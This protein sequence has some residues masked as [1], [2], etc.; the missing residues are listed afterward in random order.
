MRKML[1]ALTAVAALAVGCHAQVPPTTHT[2]ALTWTATSSGGTP[3]YSYIMSRISLTTGTSA[4]PAVNYATPNYTPLNSSAPTSG[5]AYTDSAAQGTVC[6]VVQAQD[7]AKT[8]GN[9]SNTAGPL[10][11]P[12][13]PAAPVTLGG[14]VT[15][16]LQQPALPKPSGGADAPPVVAKLEGKVN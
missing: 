3:P 9:A 6:Y 8:V 1:V 5:T 16:A 2:V 14:S 11:V 13:N 4:C 12:G 7:S 15:A 10:V